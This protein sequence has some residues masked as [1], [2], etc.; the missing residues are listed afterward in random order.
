M[1]IREKRLD[2]M[3]PAGCVSIYPAGTALVTNCL[4]YLE[5]AQLDEFVQAVEMAK[6]FATIAKSAG[7]GWPECIREMC[8]A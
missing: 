3:T 1:L 2:I 4:L 7:D 5:P 8:D 6:Q